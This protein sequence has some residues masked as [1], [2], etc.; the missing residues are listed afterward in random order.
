MINIS[1]FVEIV[2]I[3]QKGVMSSSNPIGVRPPIAPKPAKKLAKCDET[4]CLSPMELKEGE[5]HLLL[6]WY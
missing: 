2:E 6:F 1:L 3:K 4:V 5:I